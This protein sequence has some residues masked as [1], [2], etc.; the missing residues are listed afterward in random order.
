M[1]DPAQPFHSFD[2][3][4][5]VDDGSDP[6]VTAALLGVADPV[7]RP[8]ASAAD[9][10]GPRQLQPHI[11]GLINNG[12]INGTVNHNGTFNNNGTINGVINITGTNNTYGH[13]THPTTA[14]AQNTADCYDRPVV[15]SRWQFPIT[16]FRRTDP[17]DPVTNQEIRDC[18]E[19]EMRQQPQRARIVVRGK[20]KGKHLSSTSRGLRG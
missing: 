16:D 11:S 9:T 8:Q 10:L 13:A 19:L 4:D 20:E 17:N 14:D 5:Q 15:D 7:H 18:H 1:S 12:I 2:S 6:I 3:K